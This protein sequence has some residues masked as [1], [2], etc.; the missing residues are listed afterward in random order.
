MRVYKF[1]AK[2]LLLGKWMYGSLLIRKNGRTFINSTEVDPYTVGQF[3]GKADKFGKDIYEDDILLNHFFGDTWLVV[4]DQRLGQW[5]T[6]LWAKEHTED[7]YDLVGFEGSSF[8]VISNWHD[9]K[10]LLFKNA[11][12]QPAET[13]V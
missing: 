1:R 9:N 7:L 6:F 12:A 13:I 4:F 11:A 10:K 2:C 8:E 5:S 3:T